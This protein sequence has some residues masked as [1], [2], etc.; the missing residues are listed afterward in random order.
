[1]W[2]TAP[3][4]SLYQSASSRWSVALAPEWYLVIGWLFGLV[5][6]GIGWGASIILAPALLAA[7]ALSMVQAAGSASRARFLRPGPHPRGSRRALQFV[8]FS[9]HLAQPM[10]RLVGR[11]RGGLTPWRRRGPNAPPRF[12]RFE[13]SYWR[14]EREPPE[15]TLTNL[16]ADLQEA[17]AIVRDGGPFDP[18]D[19]EV[20]GG[21]LGRSRLLLAAEEHAPGKQLLRFRVSPKYARTAIGLTL[22]FGLL[23]IG[24]FGSAAWVAG[25]ISVAAAGLVIARA[26]TDAGR[27]GGILRQWLVRLGAA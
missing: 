5:L 25:A 14:D 22:A 8:V 20:V 27:S 19:L 9:L 21:S 1:V 12:G 24:A 15:W 6:L 17:G 4:Q 7:V 18:W 11:L 23:S 3:F 26:I 13:M 16:R 10:A 2:G